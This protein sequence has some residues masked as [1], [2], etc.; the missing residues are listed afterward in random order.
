MK[1]NATHSIPYEAA[2]ILEVRVVLSSLIS[3]FRTFMMI[4][5]MVTAASAFSPELM[6]LKKQIYHM[7]AGVAGS[8]YFS[9]F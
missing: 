9:N 7:A 8:W 3:V 2:M 4:S 5:E 1:L 6:V